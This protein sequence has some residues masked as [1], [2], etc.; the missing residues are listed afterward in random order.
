MNICV[1]CSCSTVD[2]KL[3]ASIQE[4]GCALGGAGH[5][6]VYGAFAEGLMGA[7]ADGFAQAGADIIGVAPKVLVD[8]GRTVHAGCKR[9]LKTISLAERKSAMIELSDAVIAAPGG[10][11][12]LDEV[13]DVLA[14]N[15]TGEL[16]MPVTFYNIGG[17]F[18]GVYDEL[19]KM[20]KAG[21]IRRPLSELVIMC[22]TPDEVLAAL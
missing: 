21:F 17:F 11:G 9:V 18:N 5:T 14:M 13:F 2:G 22:E 15:I 20:E 16:D 8:K 6:L 3:I 10:I 1:F 12:T 19:L 7:V 4:L